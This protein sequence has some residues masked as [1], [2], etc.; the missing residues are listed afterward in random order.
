[1]PRAET[2]CFSILA[3]SPK[4]QILAFDVEANFDFLLL[5]ADDKAIAGVEKWC[6]SDFYNFF[7]EPPSFEIPM[8]SHPRRPQT[9]QPGSCDGQNPNQ[10]PYGRRCHRPNQG[11]S[12][13]PH[14]RSGVSFQ[15]MASSPFTGEWGVVLGAQRLPEIQSNRVSRQQPSR[16]C[17][18]GDAAVQHPG[19]DLSHGRG[20]PRGGG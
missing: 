15:K 8:A 20:N 12:A 2:I 7:W 4:I 17:I 1:M 6:F 16:R 10:G 11:D 5:H 14:L 9:N 13:D 19:Q 3:T 18:P